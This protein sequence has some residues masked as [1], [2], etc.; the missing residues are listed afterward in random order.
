MT[1]QE[2]QTAEAKAYKVATSNTLVKTLT[3][4]ELEA[5]SDD[6]LDGLIWSLLTSSFNGGTIRE[7]IKSIVEDILTEFTSD[8][9]Q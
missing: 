8:L 9:P 1:P 5:L 4:E 7:H 2:Y 6:E 3:K